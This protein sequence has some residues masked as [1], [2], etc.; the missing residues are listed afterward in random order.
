[1]SGSYDNPDTELSGPFRPRLSDVDAATSRLHHDASTLSIDRTASTDSARPQLPNPI[2]FARQ[3]LHK[4]PDDS[5]SLESRSSSLGES[6]LGATMDRSPSK[7][8][9]T[10]Y[11]P[12]ISAVK[13]ASKQGL[14]LRRAASMTGELP[15]IVTATG[16]SHSLTANPSVFQQLDAA[17]EPQ[18]KVKACDWLD[19]TYVSC[20][21]VFVTLL[22][23]FLDDFRLA[24]LPPAADPVC[25]GITIFIFVIFVLD[26][27]AGSFVR[28]GYA[29]RFYWYAAAVAVAS[30]QILHVHACQG[31]AL[32]FRLSNPLVCMHLITTAALMH[33]FA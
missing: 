28:P 18:W 22:A 32:T 4:V 11:R 30:E 17:K 9:P 19:G 7:R 29:F 16:P 3:W 20:F 25:V 8:S 24:V 2:D 15:A 1:M 31:I 5:V 10:K 6:V 26:T 13:K 14:I 21:V 12:S 27:T 33:V 23:V